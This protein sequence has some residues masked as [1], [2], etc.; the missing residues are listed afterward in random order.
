MKFYVKNIMFIV[1]EQS[2]FNHFCTEKSMRCHI[3]RFALSATS[4]G[5]GTNTVIQSMTGL[6]IAIQESSL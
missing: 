2:S 6:C 5:Q 3:L 1:S 4:L